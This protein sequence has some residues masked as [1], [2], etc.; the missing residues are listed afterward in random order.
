MDEVTLF[1]VMFGLG[2][3]G[4]FFS[5]LLGI[6]GA[7]INYPLLLFVPTALGVATFSAQTVS[8]ISM[9]Q[10]FASASAGI[11]TYYRQKSTPNLIHTGLVLYMGSSIM[12]GTMA[13]GVLSGYLPNETIN[14]VYGV[15]AVVAV[16][17]MLIPTKE[18]SSADGSAISFNKV[19]AIFLAL[20][21]GIVSGIVGAGG[22]FILIPIML[23]VLRIPTRI[24]IAT[25]L[26]IVLLSSIGGVIGKVTAG[27]IDILPTL[28]TVLG[29]IIGASIGSKLSGKMNVKVLRYLLIILISATA[30]KIWF[31]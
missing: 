21:V 29:S 30:I 7:I 27:S 20:I 13:G 10:V 6:G 22:A 8:S 2:I 19:I 15:L 5:G 9:F 31:T 23:T 16:I 17:L 28:Y 12:I 24:T 4:S 1:I 14:L 26:A 18:K 3:V 11:W 25:S